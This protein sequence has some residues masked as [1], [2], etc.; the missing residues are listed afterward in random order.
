[1]FLFSVF[2]HKGSKCN[3]YKSTKV[4][5]GNYYIHNL[6]VTKNAINPIDINIVPH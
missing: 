1:M 3:V 2:N 5:P 4:L 6:K